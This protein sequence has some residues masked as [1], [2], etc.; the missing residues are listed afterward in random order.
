MVLIFSSHILV[1]GIVAQ[2]KIP[3]GML[4]CSKNSLFSIG[5]TDG[6]WQSAG[7]AIERNTLS[8]N[9]EDMREWF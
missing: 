1:V 4:P 6:A 7:A 5:L 2:R 8:C 9:N 3:K